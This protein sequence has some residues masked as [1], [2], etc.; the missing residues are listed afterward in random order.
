MKKPAESRNISQNRKATREI[1]I[2]ERFEAGLVLRGTEVKSLRQ[3]KVSIAEA[4]V[5]FRG[6]EA[7]LVKANIDEYDK[8]SWT[9]HDP[10][11]Q[12]KLL[13]HSREIEKLRARV[14]EK[15]LT[16]LPLSLYFNARGF[17]KVQ[18]G[19]GRG[20][21]FHDKRE[22]IKKRELNRDAQRALRR[23]AD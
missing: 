17:V 9:N 4:Y 5:I 7:F 19:L 1:E 2:L 3:G 13:L 10:H 11:R 6:G 15:G 23:D 18:L 21:K 14:E 20:K 22:D 8:G 16:I 12:R